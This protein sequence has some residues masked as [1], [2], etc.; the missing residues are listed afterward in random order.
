M[1]EKSMLD[2]K[3]IFLNYFKKV[4]DGL[5]V[6]E[7]INGRELADEVDFYFTDRWCNEKCPLREEPDYCEC[8]D[9]LEATEGVKVKLKIKFEVIDT[10]ASVGIFKKEKFELKKE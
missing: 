3:R 7:I 8:I 4:L 5:E 1:Q 6:E 9:C 2:E 10:K